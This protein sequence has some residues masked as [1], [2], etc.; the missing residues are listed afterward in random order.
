VSLFLSKLLPVFVYP[1]GLAIVLGLFA[2]ARAGRNRHIVERSKLRHSRC[3][4]RFLFGMLNPTHVPPDGQKQPVLYV[5]LER[6]YGKEI[7]QLVLMAYQLGLPVQVGL[8]KNLNM[9][10]DWVQLPKS[11]GSA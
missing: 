9:Q 7:M 4:A 5:S 1:L 11:P 2:V 8:I 10:V 3:A 6:P